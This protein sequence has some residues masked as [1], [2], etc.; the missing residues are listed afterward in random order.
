M[1]LRTELK[2][3]EELTSNVKQVQDDCWRRYFKLMR[4]RNISNV[5]VVSYD[6]VRPYIERVANGEPSNIFTGETITNF[7]LRETKIFPVNNKCFENMTFIH[8]L[9]SST[10]SKYIDGI[11]E[12]KVMAFLNTRPFITTPSGLPVAPLSTSFAMSD[13]FKNRPSKCY[14]S[15][16][17]VILC[18]DNRQN[19]YCHLLCGLAQR[20]EVVSIAAAFASSLVEAIRFLETHWK[21]LCNNI[22]SGNISEWITDR[23]CRDS[24]SVILGGPNPE[25]ADLIEHRCSHK[26]WEGMITKLWPNVKYIQTI[27]TGQMSQY[28]P[29]LEFYSN[30]LPLISPRYASSETIFGVN[31]NPLCKPNN[32]SYTFLPNM[33]YFEFLLVDEENNDEIVDLV[34]VKLGCFYEPLITNHFGLCRYRMGDIR[35]VTG[36]YNNA[37]QFR[38]VRRKYMVLSINVETTTEEDILRALNQAGLV[39]ESSDL[40]LMGFT[41]YADISTVPGHYVFYWELKA[42]NYDGI[43]KLD[44]KVMVEC[45]CVIEESFDVL[46][47]KIRNRY[48]SIGALEIRVLQQGTF[49]TL[50]EYFISKGASTS[51]YKTPLCINAPQVLAILEEKV[52]ARFFSDKFPPL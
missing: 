12:G 27:I 17:E 49:N 3:L 47:R 34:N 39:L 22:R 48:G 14:S 15:P 52:L 40:M 20:E 10:I 21:E 43:V 46:Y 35:Q 23:G 7:L 4:T 16:D 31:L 38:F 2:D 25:L 45:C 5:P 18:V 42:K 19:M 24:V 6:D 30:K 1:S 28:I 51:Q 41:C 44:N 32:V 26:S 11:G 13:Y 33:S 29:I 36:F 8:A 50:M 9:C 37:P